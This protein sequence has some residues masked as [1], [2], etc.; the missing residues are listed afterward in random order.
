[1]GEPQGSVTPVTRERKAAPPPPVPPPPPLPSVAQKAK[2][3]LLA[4]FTREEK[5]AAPASPPPPD[6]LKRAMGDKYWWSVYSEWASKKTGT[7]EAILFINAAIRYRGDPTWDRLDNI[8][9]THIGDDAAS[10][11]NIPYSMRVPLIGIAQ[12]HPVAWGPRPHNDVFNEAL[13]EV[14]KL[15]GDDYQLFKN[16][17]IEGASHRG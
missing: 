1:M 3:K 16:M 2:D 4:A 13:A 15:Q 6:T 12:T 10:M 11:V 9:N 17:W 14:I 7:P 5:K 8:V